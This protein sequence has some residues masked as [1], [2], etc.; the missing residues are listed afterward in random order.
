MSERI[1]RFLCLAGH[2][3]G[4]E[5]LRQCAKMGVRA[6]VLTLDACKH[7]SWPRD[8]IEDVAG[9]PAGLNREQILNT[10]TWM[11]RGRR[12]DRVVALDASDAEM[13]AQI[14]EYLRIPGMGMTTAAYYRDR[15]A[16]QMSVHESGFPTPAFCPVLNYDE[17]REFMERTGAPWVLKPR[18]ATPGVRMRRIHEPEQL[19]R[20]LDELG[21]LQSHFLL[22]QGITG[23]IFHVDALIDR[24][25]VLFS[26]AH[27]HAVAVKP[28][29]EPEV[30]T[31]HTL[32]RSSREW[33]ELTALNAGLAPSL[34]MVRGV[35]HTR[36]LRGQD[37]RFYFLEIA[38]GVV[39]TFTAQVVEAA[40]GVNLWREWARLEVCHLRNESYV[41]AES[42][43]TYAGCVVSPSRSESELTGFHAPEIA[44]RLKNGAHSG[45]LVRD[46]NPSRVSELV[47]QFGSELARRLAAPA[48]AEQQSL[49]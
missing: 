11:V 2:E 43:E 14:R 24:C 10:V 35:T 22:E 7:G 44:G 28:D 31:S 15:L 19:W 46:G 12:F 13:A 30:W 37:G 41:P 3:T 36:Y 26:V 6:T 8:A 23:E 27:R 18:I 1:E 42:Y 34:G 40:S 38:A 5:F 39:G 32:D 17:L 47:D 20:V 25:E 33:I 4:Y 48:R 49:F 21:D 16:Q 29:R 45:L 9:M